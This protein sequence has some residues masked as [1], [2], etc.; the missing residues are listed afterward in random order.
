MHSLVGRPAWRPPYGA[1]VRRG[2]L[3]VRAR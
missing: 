2:E 3:C 1:R